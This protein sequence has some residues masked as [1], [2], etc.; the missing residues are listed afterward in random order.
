MTAEVNTA[1]VSRTRGEQRF[2]HETVHKLRD[3]L[4]ICRLHLQMLRDVA[5]DQR[6]TIAVVVAELDR[7]AGIMA[8]LELLADAATPSFLRP[9]WIDLELFSHELTA[10]ASTLEPRNW[11]LV[12]A[13]QG[14]FFA[15][16][17]QLSEAMMSLARNALAHTGR[18]ETIAIATSMSHDE[19]RLSV[20][21][22]GPGIPAAD[23]ERI[24]DAFT[25]GADAHRRYPGSGLGLTIVKAIAEAHG[26]GV[27][28]ESRP[29]EGSTF[30]MVLPRRSSPSNARAS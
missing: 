10:Q 2:I 6:G 12:H 30:T 29:G 5:E 28:L 27:E 21:D 20:R 24:F 15:D 3:P 1:G 4:T 26:G 17:Q 25:R 14:S 8:N 11:Q 16:Q 13:G 9:E 7:M 19:C 23:Q 22:S 18:E